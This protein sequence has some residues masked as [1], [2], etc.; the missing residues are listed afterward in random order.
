VHG[1]TNP[2][3]VREEGKEQCLSCHKDKRG[4]FMF[5]HEAGAEEGCVAC[6][7]PHGGPG[8]HMLKVRAVHILCLSCHSKDMGKGAP[9]G[10]ASTTTMGDCQRC[11]SAIHGSNVDPFLLH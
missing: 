11:H 8:S 3:Q 5:E 1:S 6:H 2:R 10:R 7:A 4:P 9:H